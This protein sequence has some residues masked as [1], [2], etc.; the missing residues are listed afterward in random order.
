MP[1]LPPLYCDAR[2]ND[3]AHAEVVVVVVVDRG[4]GKGGGGYR[5]YT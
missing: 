5:V 3:E 1:D 4:R 2:R